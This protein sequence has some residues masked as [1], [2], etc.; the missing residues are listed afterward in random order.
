MAARRYNDRRVCCNATSP[1][2]ATL[3]KGVTDESK[4]SI[5]HCPSALVSRR[6]GVRRMGTRSMAARVVLE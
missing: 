3:A 6:L 5:V 2:P 1:E 4:R